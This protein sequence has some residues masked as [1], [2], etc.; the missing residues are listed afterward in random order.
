MPGEDEPSDITAD[1][2]GA[3]SMPTFDPDAPLKAADV[4]HLALE[5]HELRGRVLGMEG[6]LK[7]LVVLLTPEVESE[8]VQKA[9]IHLRER[10]LEVA[11]QL[12]AGVLDLAKTLIGSRVGLVLSL[13]ILSIAIPTGLVIRGSFSEGFTIEPASENA[14]RADVENEHD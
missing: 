9:T 2:G 13:A 10:C 6:Q 11:G 8:E 14:A 4:F 5:V 7:Q 12:G 1:N 3:P